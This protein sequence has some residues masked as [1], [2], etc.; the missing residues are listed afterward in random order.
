MLTSK[1]RPFTRQIGIRSSVNTTSNKVAKGLAVAHHN[2]DAFMSNCRFI[3][4]DQEKHFQELGV[5]DDQGLTTFNTLHELQVN[6]SL[7]F[8]ENELFGT[9]EEQSKSY[10][11]ITYDEYNK[12]V[13]QCRVLLKELGEQSDNITL[14]YVPH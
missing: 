7:V 11:Y 1:L 12:K 6:S 3:T 8:K 5:L 4:T 14:C 9:Y 13:N 2:F 10:N